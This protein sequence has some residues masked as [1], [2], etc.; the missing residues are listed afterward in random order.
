M[1]RSGATATSRDELRHRNLRAVLDAIHRHGPI[2]RSQLRD[3]LGLSGAS[4]TSLTADLIGAGVVVEAEEGRSDRAGRKPILLA[5]DYDHAQVAGV[6]VGEQVA[7]LALTNLRAEVLATTSIELAERG[8][9]AVAD[10]I[11]AGLDGLRRSLPAVPARFVSVGVSLP[12]IVDPASGTVRCSPYDAWNGV[13][14]ASMLGERIGSP[15]L[16]ENDVNALANAEAWF[17]SGRG[18]DDF[19]VVTLGR[20]VGLGIVIGGAV[21]RGPHGGAGE[22][23]HAPVARD[24]A[25]E[26]RAV[27]DLLSDATIVRAANARA[28]AAGAPAEPFA[29]AAAVVAAADAGDDAALDALEAAGTSLGLVLASLVD[30]FA[31]TLIVLGGEGMRAAQYLLPPARSALATWAFGDLGDRVELHVH[32]WGD[33]V[34]ARGAAGLAASDYLATITAGR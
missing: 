31:P 19:L 8:P 34:W 24:A 33:D 22:L 15:I 6:K 4:L 30:I 3:G 16:L 32:A 21:Y 26:P 27:E 28:A 11:A 14:F 1:P 29:D 13:P 17:G 10:A 7:T 20:G 5:V 25:G 23:G 9:D 12:G 2:S 18:H